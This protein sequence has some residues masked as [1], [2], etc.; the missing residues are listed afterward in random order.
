MNAHLW[1]LRRIFP[2]PFR[3]RALALLPWL[4]LG[5]LWWLA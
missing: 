3:R 4:V 5:A 2:A 1:L